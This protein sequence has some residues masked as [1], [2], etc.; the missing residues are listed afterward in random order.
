MYNLKHRKQTMIRKVDLM[1]LHR[2][3]MVGENSLEK[4]D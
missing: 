1:D 2:E 3:A 4:S